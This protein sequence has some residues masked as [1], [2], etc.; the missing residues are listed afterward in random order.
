MNSTAAAALS[1]AS[2][3]SRL[4]LPVSWER[5]DCAPSEQQ[6]EAAEQA[7]AGIL[8]FLLQEIELDARPR[9]ADE[10]LVEALAPLAAKLDV[11]VELVTRLSYRDAE[12]PPRRVIELGERHR[13]WQAPDAE[14]PGVWLRL[15]IYFHPTFLE[16]VVLFGEVTETN[17]AVG[18]G[19]HIE[20]AVAEGPERVSGDLLRLALLTQRR[21]HAATVAAARIA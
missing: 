8:S 2:V 16:P 14:P 1:A 20:V 12:R 10:Q 21:Q 7:N 11:V 9:P 13:A 19:F 4:E 6:R 3:A 17:P 15:S 18:S 5:L